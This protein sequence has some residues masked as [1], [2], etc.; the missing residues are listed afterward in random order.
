MNKEEFLEAIEAY[1][2]GTANAFQ[3]LIIEDYFNSF[4]FEL[5]ILDFIPDVEIEAMEERM[6]LG[7]MKRIKQFSGR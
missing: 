5:N 6:Y 4:S 1:L 2:N 7:I 3:E